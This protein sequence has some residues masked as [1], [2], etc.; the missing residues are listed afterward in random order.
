[1]HCRLHSPPSDSSSTTS[2]VERAHLRLSADEAVGLSQ[3]EQE[4]RT[5]CICAQTYTLNFALLYSCT[6]QSASG[7]CKMSTKVI[8]SGTLPHAYSNWC[9]SQSIR[10]QIHAKEFIPVQQA[11]ILCA[12]CNE[13]TDCGLVGNASFSLLSAFFA[14]HGIVRSQPTDVL[15]LLCLPLRAFCPGFALL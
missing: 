13:P 2:Q 10:R 5:L 4:Q 1:M 14:H 12:D 15:A 6:R 7:D 9:G 8:R 3:L 11:H